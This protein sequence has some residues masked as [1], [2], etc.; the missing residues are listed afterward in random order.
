MNF[1]KIDNDM[2]LSTDKF[3]IFERIGT[4]GFTLYNYL[5]TQQAQKAY[6]Q[7]NIKMI[8]SFMD[9]E[10]RNGKDLLY[11]NK[12]C[13]V[14]KLK[15]RKLALKNLRILRDNELIKLD[16]DEKELT[17]GLNEIITVKVSKIETNNFTM[18]SEDLFVDYIHKIGHIGWSLLYILTKLH[19]DNFGSSTSE[20][21]ANVS[22]QYLK[23]I[24]KRN[25]KTIGAY[26]NLLESY[27]LI[28]IEK[29][30]AIYR[31]ENKHGQE[32]YEYVPNNYIVK[33]RLSD[34]KYY[35]QPKK[36]EKNRI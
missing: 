14:S 21:F 10:T 8:I 24:I 34:N 26:L 9:R 35:I 20:G 19:N 32:I 22:Q 6:C 36:K 33:N 4:E 3:N 1:I 5:L 27:K 7:I 29:N 17:Y 30:E 18:I 28:K 15:S 13:K 31:G 16:T 11:I 25:E 12:T 2:L 23:S